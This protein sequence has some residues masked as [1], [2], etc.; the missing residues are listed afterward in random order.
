MKNK[1]FPGESSIDRME[2]KRRMATSSNVH[3]IGKRLVQVRDA[4]AGFDPWGS[5]RS[6]LRSPM[7]TDQQSGGDSRLNEPQ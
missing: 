5:S 2:E 3:G 6:V 1:K 4:S 7:N